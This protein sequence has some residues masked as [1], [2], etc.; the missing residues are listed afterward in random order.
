MFDGK[1]DHLLNKDFSYDTGADCLATLCAYFDTI[2]GITVRNN[3]ARYEGWERDGLNLF[4]ENYYK[5]GFRLLDIPRSDNWFTALQDGDV[6]LMSL[7]SLSD[8]ANTGVANHCA[9]WLEPRMMLNH[10]Y[11]RK[12]AIIPFKYKNSTT[13]ILRHKDLPMKKKEVESLDVMSILSP[14]KRDL[15]RDAQRATE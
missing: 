4:V 13:H 15:L 14:R 12:S 1:Y 5:E 7:H 8:R 6:L 9:I 10:M 11:G 2:H 3:Y